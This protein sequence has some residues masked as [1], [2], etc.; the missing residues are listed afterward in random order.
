MELCL[1]FS[2]ILLA[3]EDEENL[4]KNK[5]ALDEIT[6]NFRTQTS[7]LYKTFKSIEK[8]QMGTHLEQLLTRINFN[9]YMEEREG[10]LGT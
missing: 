9:N 1:S 3:Y 10:H 5:A 2:S 8:R 6:Q 7:L 4:V